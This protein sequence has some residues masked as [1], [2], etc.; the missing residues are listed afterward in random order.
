VSRQ[1]IPARD[2]NTEADSR[3]RNAR[4]QPAAA[5]P[6]YSVCP[7]AS[8]TRATRAGEADV[9]LSASECA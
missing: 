8:F 2:N 9:S 5:L 6:P 7:I 3:T 4:G 1:M